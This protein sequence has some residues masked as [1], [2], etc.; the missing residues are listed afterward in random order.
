M[1]ETCGEARMG[2]RPRACSSNG[3][4]CFKKELK[5]YSG[6]SGDKQAGYED[7]DWDVRKN[8]SLP[9]VLNFNNHNYSKYL[10]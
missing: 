1:V 2:D 6:I 10:L 5:R 9:T 3:L 7:G 8:V 4:L